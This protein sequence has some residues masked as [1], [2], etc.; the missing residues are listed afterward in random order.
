MGHLKP[1][2]IVNWSL[3]KLDSC[4]PMR[5]RGPRYWLEQKASSL[6][7]LNFPRQGHP[8]DGAVRNYVSICSSLGRP[9]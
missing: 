3:W 8:R 5:L 7:A 4:P 9:R 1:I 2:W 6:V